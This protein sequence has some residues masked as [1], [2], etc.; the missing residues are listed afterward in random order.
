MRWRTLWT[1]L[2]KPIWCKPP[3]CLAK[4]TSGS[5]STKLWSWDTFPPKK[6]LNTAKRTTALKQKL[7]IPCLWLCPSPPPWWAT[8]TKLSWRCPLT[9]SRTLSSSSQ[10][11]VLSWPSSRTFTLESSN[12]K[13]A[14]LC[15]KHPVSSTHL[16]RLKLFI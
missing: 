11:T 6:N 12:L 15:M 3:Q 1:T 5:S 2:A 13:K 7:K 4:A 8:I 9:A 16:G 14:A 10:I